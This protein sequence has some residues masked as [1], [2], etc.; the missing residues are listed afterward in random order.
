MISS[1]FF[2]TL[3]LAAC[4]LVAIQG[5]SL[6]KQRDRSRSPVNHRSSSPSNDNKSDLPV[7]RKQAA[8]V[9]ANAGKKSGLEIWRI[10]VK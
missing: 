8:N 1:G 6:D 9:F 7:N 2:K 4:L 10:E 3:L 5:A